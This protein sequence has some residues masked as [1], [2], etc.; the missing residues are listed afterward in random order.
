MQL[1]RSSFES[2]AIVTRNQNRETWQRRASLLTPRADGEAAS[3]GR[4][5]DARGCL[6]RP[7]RCPPPPQ[8]ASHPSTE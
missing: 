5:R 1:Q 4:A 7:S 6:V 8:H 2:V 3:V